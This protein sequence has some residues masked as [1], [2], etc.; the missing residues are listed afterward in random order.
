MVARLGAV[1]GPIDQAATR[2]RLRALGQAW[3]P[4]RRAGDFAQAVMELGATVCAPRAP[5][6][7][8]CP[9]ASACG[10]RRQGLTGRI[11]SKTAR[12]PKRVVQMVS[13]RV[14]RAGRVLLIRRGTGLLAGTWMLPGVVIAD[15]GVADDVARATLRDLGIPAGRVS[16]V[17][18][19]R[20]LFTHRDVTVDVFDGAPARTRPGASAKA[21]RVDDAN[22]VWA[23]EGNL[24]G[25]AVSSF[26][27]KQLALKRDKPAESP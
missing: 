1:R 16:H 11:P 15:G 19:I 21:S 9:L 7:D 17:G 2:D 27:R 23:D 22:M 20:H 13:V 5:A 26:L 12:R 3:V 4:A 8:E 25:L 24:G 10:A 14:R 6:C 18:S